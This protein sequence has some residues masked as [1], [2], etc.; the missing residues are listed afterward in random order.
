MMQLYGRANM[1]PDYVRFCAEARKARIEAV[2]Q[3]QREREQLIDTI[4][5]SMFW[6]ACL[7]IA[8]V[9]LFIL[10]KVLLNV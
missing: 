8:G 7:G 4:L 1:Y 2:K 6:A 3:A 5:V 10:I 9:A